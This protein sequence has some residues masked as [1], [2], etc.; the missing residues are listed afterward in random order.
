MD[1]TQS[2]FDKLWIGTSKDNG[3]PITVEYEGNNAFCNYYGLLGHTIGFCRKKRNV[4]GKLNTV[5][6][7]K[8][9]ND[10]HNSKNK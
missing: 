10:E 7:K 2:F 1:V 3:W 4:Q 5:E 8:N 9:K 6:E